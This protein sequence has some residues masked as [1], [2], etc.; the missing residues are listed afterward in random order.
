MRKR[1]NALRGERRRKEQQKEALVQ[2]ELNGLR[3]TVR[4]LQREIAMLQMDKLLQNDGEDDEEEEESTSDEDDDS[5]RDS[6]Q[7]LKGAPKSIFRKRLSSR[8]SG[9]STLKQRRSS[10]VAA[11]VAVNRIFEQDH[12]SAH[13]QL[14]YRNWTEN[15]RLHKHYS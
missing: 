9:S 1:A 5:N 4:Q 15:A 11:A 8:A 6:V 7:N 13:A 3:D 2:E 14:L 12:G 10:A